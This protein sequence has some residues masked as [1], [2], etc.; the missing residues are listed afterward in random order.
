MYMYPMVWVWCI[1]GGKDGLRH[2]NSFTGSGAILRSNVSMPVGGSAILHRQ[3][4]LL[5]LA[6]FQYMSVTVCNSVLRF[7]LTY[8]THLTYFHNKHGIKEAF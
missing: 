4:E 6:P 3:L 7:S 1:D 5:Y 2:L 8:K